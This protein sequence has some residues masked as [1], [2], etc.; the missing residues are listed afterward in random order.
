MGILKVYLETSALNFAFTAQSPDKKADTL[1][2]FD[3][4][5]EGRYSLFTSEYVTEEIDKAPSEKR[6]SIYRLILEHDIKI[7]KNAVEIE[8]LAEE[9]VKEGIIPRKHM[10]DALHIA[11]AAVYGLD[12]IVS[13]NF[14]HIVK[15]KTIHHDR[16][17]ES[18]ERL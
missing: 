18:A 5:K 16:V 9:Y 17:G 8:K 2:M 10:M 4:F 7:L 14:R 11:A 13:W 6:D 3:V 1:K 12:I 15:R